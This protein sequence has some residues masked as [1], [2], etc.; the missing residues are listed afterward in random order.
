MLLGERPD[1]VPLCP[2][3]ISNGVA[4]DG[5]RTSGV[6]GP[7]LLPEVWHGLCGV[8]A[9]LVLYMC[10]CLWKACCVT[11]ATTVV[12]SLLRESTALRVRAL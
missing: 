4:L 3:G 10:V 5:P 9:S 7:G 11:V 2:L 8:I 1:L 6:R 12:V